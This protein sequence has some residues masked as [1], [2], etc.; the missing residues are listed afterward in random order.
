MN[1]DSRHNLE[2][3][4]LN[5]CRLAIGS[6]PSFDYDA[7]GGG[8]FG[9]LHPTTKDNNTQHIEFNTRTFKIPPLTY[10]TTKFLSLPLPPGLKIEMAMDSL[11][12]TIN[13]ESGRIFLKFESRFVFSIFSLFNF[14]W[15]LRSWINIAGCKFV[16][17]LS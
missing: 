2:L 17:V 3:I 13:K 10:K 6:Y 12:G 9:T 1:N 8:G 15:V 14:F 16:W 5:G 11:E 7:S 4:S